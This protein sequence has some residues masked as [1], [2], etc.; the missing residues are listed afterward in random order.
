MLEFECV[1]ANGTIVTASP[2]AHTDLFWALRGG[3]NLFAVVT[4]VTLR[5]RPVGRDAIVWGGVRTYSRAQLPRLLAAIA[6]FAA[7]ATPDAR[8]AIA[9]VVRFLDEL[10]AH[11][12]AAAVSFFYDAPL[13]PPAAFAAFAAIPHESDATRTRPYTSLVGRA[14]DARRRRTAAQTAAN[15]FPVAPRRALARFL[16][17]HHGAVVD[18]AAASLDHASANFSLASYELQPV[19]APLLAA[20]A[21]AAR[22]LR[23]EPGPIGLDAAR[24]ARLFVAYEAA[25][26]DPDCDD[27]CPNDVAD[28]A[29]NALRLHM[30][31]F[32]GPLAANSSTP[33]D[34]S[35]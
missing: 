33:R 2:R 22:E 29:K 12:P 16:A 8:A 32:A 6:S 27:Y 19:Q 17:E 20:S 11:R 28:M 1:L 9:P 25:W 31:R 24:G 18:A 3:G 13:P 21:A 30:G 15:T 5:T 7:N 14:R 23:A 10:R 35:M 4:R 26:S 34:T